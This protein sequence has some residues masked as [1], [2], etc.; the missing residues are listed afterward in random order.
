MQTLP[1]SGT[2]LGVG[3]RLSYMAFDGKEMLH[4][5][6][7]GWGNVAIKSQLMEAPVMEEF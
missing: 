6:V 1:L 7:S 3:V 5:N 2:A 4:L